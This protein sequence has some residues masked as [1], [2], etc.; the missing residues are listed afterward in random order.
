MSD[1]I[2]RALSSSRLNDG[3]GKRPRELKNQDKVLILLFQL[4]RALTRS[5]GD[6][7]TKAG[8]L[9]PYILAALDTLTTTIR[10]EPMLMVQDSL[11]FTD[12]I[13]RKYTLQYEHFKNLRVGI[14]AT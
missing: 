7:L 8:L 3:S 12:A 6:L 13:G 14:P 10:R 2:L 1:L 4:L 5:M 9:L 11:N